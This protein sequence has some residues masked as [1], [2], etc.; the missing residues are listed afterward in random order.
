MVRPM[1]LAA[2]DRQLASS[3]R[4]STFRAERTVFC[5]EKVSLKSFKDLGPCLQTSQIKESAITSVADGDTSICGRECRKQHGS[6]HKKSWSQ[7]TTL[8]DAI[9]VWEWVGQKTLF[10]YASHHSIM[11]R[12][13]DVENPQRTAKLEE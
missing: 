6:K 11:E 8:L 4:S 5:K 1:A 2:V 13:D 7:C 3:C 10:H 9:G 12:P